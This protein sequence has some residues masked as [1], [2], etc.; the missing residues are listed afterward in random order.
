M[1]P[2]G[3][4]HISTLP[5]NGGRSGNVGIM[6]NPEGRGKGFGSEAIRLCVNWVLK[7]WDSQR[8]R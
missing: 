4:G 1:G 6:L 2:S 7:P 5:D 3:F 8:R